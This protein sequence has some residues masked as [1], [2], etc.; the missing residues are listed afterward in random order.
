M[1][2][3]RFLFCALCAVACPLLADAAAA[4]KKPLNVLFV[5][6]DDQRFDTIA[7]LG[8]SEIKTPN[9]D[10]LVKRGFTFS[11]AFCQ[12]AMVPAV[13]SPSRTMLMTGK[14]LFR[15]PAPNA[16]QY[17]G[18][19]LGSV[20]RSAGYA[21]LF[22]GKPGNS[23][24]VGNQAFETVIY[25]E[26]N[27]KGGGRAQQSQCTAD[28]TLRWLKKRQNNKQPFFIY[29]GPPVP[30]DP[31]VAPK[32]F[33]DMYDS[34][35]I[36]LPKNFMPNHPFDNGELKI[37]DELL[38]PFPR[39]PDVMKKHIA[40]YYACITCFD[41]HLGRIIAALEQSG[42][43]E[44]TLIVYTSDHGLAVGGRHGLMG[45]QNLYE[46]VKPPLLIAGPRVPH[47]KSNAL[48]YLFDL[49]PTVVELAKL[50]APKNVDGLSLAPI[51][52]GD[53][54]RVRE[55]L[56]AAYRNCQRMVRDERWKV[57]WY[58]LIDR[59]QMFDVVEDPWELNDVHARPEQA[60]RFAE[61][62]QRLTA[63]QKEFG[64]DKAPNPK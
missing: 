51:L 39:T 12:G 63:L 61:L 32:E 48:V 1:T 17:D 31:R 25:N 29:L 50:P 16:K 10:K 20:F 38:A 44:N 42:E 46:H 64:D 41:H 8:N 5:V 35:R 49:F 58:P 52:R 23:F 4:P 18:P 36:T 57:I 53:K 62:K 19:T 60:Q 9:L 21:T 59:Y 24:T 22:I 14:S 27:K 56:F 13:C 45:K 26:A 6:T 3:V 7:A 15:I 37:R 40:E 28:E 2:V 34:A 33:M 11:N 54:E 47:G 55:S 30:H 43:L